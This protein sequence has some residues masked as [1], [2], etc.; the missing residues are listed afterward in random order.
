MKRRRA[1]EGGSSKK[2]IDLTS[3]KCCGKEV[4][5]DEAKQITEKQR[6]LH[7]YGGEEDLTSVWSEYFPIS[8]VA[9]EHLFRFDWLCGRAYTSSV[10]ASMC[11]SPP[12]PWQVR[13]TEGSR[14]G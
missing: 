9:E 5:L 3:A 14:G 10:H 13:R 7:G 11:C 12:L 6:K 1:D 4:S 2:V 8:V